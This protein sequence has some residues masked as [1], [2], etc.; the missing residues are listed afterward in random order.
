MT[1]V[2]GSGSSRQDSLRR[3]ES[4]VGVLVRRIRKVIGERARAVH[5]DLQ[6]SSYLI[7][8]HLADHGPKRASAL[9]DLF[10]IDKG[11]VSRQVQHLLDLGLLDRVPDPEDGRA[12]LVSAS[13]EAVRRMADVA[14]MRRA[15]LDERLGDWSDEQLS[16]FVG[17]LGRYNRALGGGA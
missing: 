3:L 15:W 11:A 7:L 16:G 1:G 2:A 8:A 13:D 12:S 14:S 17:E 10:D 4:E 6:P 9:V 5:P